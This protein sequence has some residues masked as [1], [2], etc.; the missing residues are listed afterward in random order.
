MIYDLKLYKE[1]KNN[2]KEINE[3]AYFL[4]NFVNILY[5]NVKHGSQVWRTIEEIESLRIEIIILQD[6]Y[7]VILNS[8]SKKDLIKGKL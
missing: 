2:I 1:A 7:N 6:H 3:L 8:K 4:D 5:N